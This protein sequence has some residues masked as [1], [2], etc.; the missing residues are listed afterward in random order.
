MRRTFIGIVLAAVIAVLFARHLDEAGAARR[1]DPPRP[2]TAADERLLQNAEQVLVRQ[3]MARA[4]FDYTVVTPTEKPFPFRYVLDDVGWARQ[5]GYGSD[6][7]AR[8]RARKDPNQEYFRGLTRVRQA[9]ALVALNGP[10]PRGLSARLPDGSTMTRSDTGCT[11]E[12]QRRLYRDAGTWFQA[13][14]VATSL[15]STRFARVTADPQY[16]HAVRIW[17]G[18]M[19]ARGHAAVDPAQ[20][21]ARFA[22]SSKASSHPNA[23]ESRR[24]EIDFA[25]AEATCAGSSGLGALARR[26]DAHYDQILRAQARPLLQERAELQRR[27]LPAARLIVRS[28]DPQPRS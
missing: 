2:V 17:S 5:H 4:G 24:S 13:S 10:S 22:D 28:N 21:Q 3:C 11:T 19:R 6:L 26:L 8:L 12:A 18:C 14:M 1:S 20:A 9:A 7:L 15:P 23:T 25:T 16:R 27:A